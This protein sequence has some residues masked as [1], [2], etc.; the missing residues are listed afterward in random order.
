[1][2]YE[3]CVEN[4]RFFLVGKRDACGAIFENAG[5]FGSLAKQKLYSLLEAARGCA[6]PLSI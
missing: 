5:F 6:D 4:S 3:N 2:G 1:M